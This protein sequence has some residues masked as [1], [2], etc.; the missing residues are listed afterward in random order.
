MFWSS[1][2]TSRE[3]NTSLLSPRKTPCSGGQSFHFPASKP[4]ILY[5][6]LLFVIDT[7]QVGLLSLPLRLNLLLF[8][9]DM[10]TW[11]T[12]VPGTPMH[13]PN[14]W[15]NEQRWQQWYEINICEGQSW[16]IPIK[17]LPQSM[18]LSELTFPDSSAWEQHPE[19]CKYWVTLGE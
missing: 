7:L 6:P 16:L 11:H 14:M 8:T 13:L 17:S 9:W 18:L 1:I 19:K 2:A 4:T 12:N 3:S 15:V 5:L 10:G